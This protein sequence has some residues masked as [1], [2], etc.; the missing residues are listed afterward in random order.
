MLMP[1]SL[2]FVGAVLVL[3]GLWMAGRISD[4]EIVVINFV[5]S[6]ITGTVALVSLLRADDI[7]DVRGVAV[8]LLF[9]VTYLWV[10]L[11][12]F[13]GSD[14]SGLGWFS[15]FVALSV[16]PETYR[17]LSTA[18]TFMDVWMGLNWAAWSGL[19]F[20]YFLV[21]ALKKPIQRQTSLVTFSSGVLTAW[22][23]ALFMMYGAQA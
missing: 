2:L 13:N 10:A 6:A 4:R 8:T 21:L 3:N 14:G 5:T 17:T 9:S 23:P 12:R 16:L 20:M 7:A 18:A 1:L 11:N 15:L 19:W 22:M